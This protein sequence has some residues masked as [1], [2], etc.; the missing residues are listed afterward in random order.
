MILKF[1]LNRWIHDCME[2][3][4]AFVLNI[5]GKTFLKKLVNLII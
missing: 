1:I 4:E 2:Y 3:A 5:F